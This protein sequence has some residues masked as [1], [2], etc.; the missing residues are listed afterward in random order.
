MGIHVTLCMVYLRTFTVGC[1][2]P[3]QM[4]VTHINTTPNKNDKLYVDVYYS[5]VYQL[6][7][8]QV[9]QLYT[10]CTFFHLHGNSTYLSGRGMC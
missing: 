10:T 8:V 7:P 3:E 4:H 1:T 6:S 5:D 9:L 2:F